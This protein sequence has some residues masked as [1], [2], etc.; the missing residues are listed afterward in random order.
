MQASPPDTVCV[1]VCVLCTCVSRRP[2]EKVFKHCFV[3]TDDFQLRAQPGSGFQEFWA[4]SI[5]WGRVFSLLFPPASPLR[6]LS[7]N[8]SAAPVPG[9]PASPT[10]RTKQQSGS[11]ADYLYGAYVLSNAETIPLPLQPG[12]SVAVVSDRNSVPNPNP[13]P[14][15]NR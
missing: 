12:R 11:S 13:A 1:R 2:R 5:G 9:L 10:L 4:L 8:R 7:R 3:S 14:L 15:A 6:P